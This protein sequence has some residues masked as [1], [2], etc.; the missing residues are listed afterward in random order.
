MKKAV[1]LMSGGLDS[2]VTA[3]I[4]SLDYELYFLHVNYGQKTE[5]RELKSFNDLYKHFNGRDKLIVDIGYLKKIGGSSLVDDKENIEAGNVERKDIPRTYVPFRNGN[6]LSIG[7][8]WAEVIGAQKIFIGAVAEDSSGYPDCRKEFYDAFN[9]V[10]KV[11][12]KP[13][14]ELSIETPIIDMTKSEIVKIGSELNV[15]FHLTWSCYKNE[16]KACGVC[17]SCLLRLRGF[18]KAGIKDPIPYDKVN[19]SVED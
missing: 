1:V 10:L 3:G 19:S 6:I 8:S 2:C 9:E 12:L 7:V 16:T 4:A 11:G 17:D 15:P 14:T 18:E 13:E 5:K